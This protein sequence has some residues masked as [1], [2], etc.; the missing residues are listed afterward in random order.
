MP[1]ARLVKKNLPQFRGAAHMYEV[2]PPVKSGYEWTPEEERKEYSFI[3]ISQIEGRYDSL[4]IYHYAETYVFGAS[5]LY[6]TMLKY[7]PEHIAYELAVEAGEPVN[8]SEL[9]GSTKGFYEHEEILRI[10]G[11]DLVE[12]RKECNG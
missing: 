12:H 1:S 2:F 9:R 10:M 4:D 8:Y 7:M 6:G 5:T 11:Y 3:I